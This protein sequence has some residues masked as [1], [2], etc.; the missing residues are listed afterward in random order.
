MGTDLLEQVKD[1]VAVLTLNR[2]DR[3]NAMSRPMLDALLE[4]LPIG[5]LAEAGEALGADAVAAPAVEDEHERHRARGQGRRHVQQ[6]GPG[7]TADLDRVDLGGTVG[8]GGEHHGHA[9]CRR[10]QPDHR[11]SHRR[12]FIVQSPGR[13]SAQG[14]P[15]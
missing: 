1:G 6:V 2:P 3:L 15:R 13:V 10:E 7:E 12:S 5:E 9:P 14:E 11:A 8:R 4:A